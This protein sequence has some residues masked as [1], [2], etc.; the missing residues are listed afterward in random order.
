MDKNT[1]FSHV[2]LK[3]SV[4]INHSANITSCKTVFA[5]LSTIQ[6]FLAWLN[7]GLCMHNIETPDR[8][9]DLSY[10]SLSNLTDRVPMKL[11]KTE[12][13]NLHIYVLFCDLFILI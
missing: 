1:F 3:I 5:Y 8:N 11:R 9:M 4:E 7:I 13:G 12:S 2:F 10:L 6:L